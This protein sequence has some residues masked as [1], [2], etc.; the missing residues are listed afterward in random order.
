MPRATAN[1]IHRVNR[2]VQQAYPGQ[3]AL[4]HRSLGFEFSRKSTHELPDRISKTL[5]TQ[6]KRK[7]NMQTILLLLFFEVNKKY[8]CPVL[9]FKLMS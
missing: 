1:Y 2:I 7:I 5:G 9:F 4:C 8:V 6:V 3:R